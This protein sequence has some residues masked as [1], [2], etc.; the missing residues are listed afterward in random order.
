MRRATITVM[1]GEWQSYEVSSENDCK[2]EIDLQAYRLAVKKGQAI[3]MGCVCVELGSR[4]D[5]SEFEEMFN[6]PLAV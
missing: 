6:N 4:P 3:Q 5:I 1:N 2:D